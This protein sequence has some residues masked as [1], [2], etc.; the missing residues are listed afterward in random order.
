MR[1]T[2]RVF[3]RAS[4]PGFA[5]GLIAALIVAAAPACAGE[6]PGTD[7]TIGQTDPDVLTAADTLQPA[8]PAPEFRAFG[9]EPFWALDVDSAELR[10]R[11]PEDTSGLRFGPVQPIL[12]GDS[13]R[14][15]T[16]GDSGTLEL[17]V[18]QAPCSDGMSDSTWS[19]TARLVI[20]TRTFTGCAR[21]R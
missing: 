11:T 14:W 18:R 13:L 15:T 21:R 6:T 19:H 9:N 10:F 8:P 4:A 17:I 1:N 20:G 2:R 5:K 16:I 7:D 12:A 3:G